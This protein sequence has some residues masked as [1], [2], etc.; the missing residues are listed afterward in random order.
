[1]AVYILLSMA[2]RFVVAKIIGLPVS[3][4]AKNV[5]REGPV[6]VVVTRQSLTSY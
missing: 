6:N 3:S 1:M 5:V 4:A 2:P